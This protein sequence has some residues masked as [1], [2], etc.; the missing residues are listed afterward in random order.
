MFPWKFKITSITV[1]KCQ[2]TP[3]PD[4]QQ[5]RAISCEARGNNAES[6]LLSGSDGSHHEIFFTQ[7]L[8][9][10]LN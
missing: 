1:P 10:E 7:T 3:F 5:N 8:A 2:A 9:P 6:A 4:A